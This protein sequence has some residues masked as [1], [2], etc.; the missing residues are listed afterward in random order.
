MD[1]KKFGAG[2]LDVSA[3]LAN[4][5]VTLVKPTKGSTANA[6]PDFKIDVRGIDP[7]T[8]AIYLDYADATGDGLPDNIAN[9]VPALAGVA[10]SYYLNLT[11][12]SLAFNWAQVSPNAPL[13]PG[14][15]FVYATAKTTVGADTLF[16]WG[17]FTVASKVIPAGQ[18][19]FAFPYALTTTSP[20]STVTV[21]ALPSDILL[22]A[23]TSQPLDFRVQ[24]PDRAR[25]VRWSAPQ[26][27]YRS[28]VTGL[29]DP[30]SNAPSFD[31]WAWLNPIT[32]M[33]LPRGDIQPVPT[34]GG[35]LPQD[36]R[37]NLQFPAG[38]GFWLIL[39]KDA[40]ISSAFTEISAPQGFSIYLYKGWNLVGNPY[41]KDVF[42][43]KVHLSYQGATRTLDEDQLSSRPWVDPSIYGYT[44]GSGYEI[45]PPGRRLLEP[46]HGYWIRALVG[47]ISPLESLVMT[48]Q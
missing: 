35:F 25:L 33:L 37:A 43:S 6:Y 40:V 32:R 31:D 13:T 28:Y 47:G 29:A 7:N 23:S 34:A 5:S 20:D 19:L 4:G 46:Y 36:P 24:I 9:E 30:A 2:I 41:T 45:V 22:D 15:H 26:F 44:S 18:H 42:L 8:I 3:A 1:R 27:L 48:V 17:T 10:A 11:Q 14:L 12:T 39:Q 16:D 38:T 21:T